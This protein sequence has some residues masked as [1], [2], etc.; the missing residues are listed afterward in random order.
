MKKSTALGYWKPLHHSFKG[1]NPELG[2]YILVTG[3]R[4]HNELFV[5]A[6]SIMMLERLEKEPGKCKMFFWPDEQ[7]GIRLEE[8]VEEI[9]RKMSFIP[10]KE[11]EKK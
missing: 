6:D 9:F 7:A 11:E 1:N 10:M 2:R 8:S 5:R 4:D 3:A